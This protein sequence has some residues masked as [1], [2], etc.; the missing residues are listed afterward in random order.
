MELRPYRPSD[1]PAVLGLFYDTVHSVNCGDYTPEQLDAWAD[2]RPD[3][4]RWNQSLLSH[5]TLVAVEDG[6]LVGFGDMDGTG[7]LD[8]L[9]VHRDYL[10]RG[11]A[12]ALCDALE[13]RLSHG[14]FTTHA[15]ITARP[16]FEGRGYTVLRPQTVYRHG[17][18]LTNF[19]MEKSG[20]NTMSQ[21]I[22]GFIGT[23]NMGGALARAACRRLAPDRVLLSNRTAAKAEELA[24][25][26]GC[27]AGASAEAAAQAQYIFLG[28]KPQMMAGLLEEIAPVLAR[29][30]D[31]FVLVSMAAGLTME[32]IAAMAGGN[33]PVIR[34]MPNTPCAVGAGMVLY[35][36]NSLVAEQELETFTAAMA[37]AGVLD[38]LE[39][40]LMDAGSAVAGCGPA[41][42]C[43]FIEALA[44]G[45]VAC[46]LPRQK[47]LLYAAQM[48][49]GT[50]RLML[51]TRQHPGAMKDAV[52]SPGGST[53]AG[54]RALEQHGVRAAAMDAV[55]AAVERTR[56]LGR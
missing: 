33:Y 44:D 21:Y 49:E 14:V 34:I 1:L 48:M 40:R 17:V 35:D 28:V 46:G 22:F 13:R 51:E 15:S 39:E 18:A 20:G 6:L 53:I 16:F 29:R 24:R 56:E 36:A 41:F 19:V 26:L 30:T 25:E 37:G 11:V 12:T 47:A 2:G 27:H 7:Y 32:R 55:I 23:G 42:V 54:V 8:R 31:R 52:C 43:Q 4:E 38:R 5:H 10:R 50:A 3:P 9:Y 45:G